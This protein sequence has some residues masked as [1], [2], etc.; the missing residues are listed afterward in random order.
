MGSNFSSIPHRPRFPCLPAPIFL[1]QTQQD[2]AFSVGGTAYPTWP[3]LS[4]EPLH[5]QPRSP[6]SWFS[7]GCAKDL[8]SQV[9]VKR[10]RPSP[11]TLASSVLWPLTQWNWA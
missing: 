1:P 2:L 7:P 9:A 11:D 3:G 10:I 8:H 6:L 4:Q 5:R